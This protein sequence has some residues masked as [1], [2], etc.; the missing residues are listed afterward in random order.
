MYLF[1]GH[2]RWRSDDDL[3]S[4]IDDGDAKQ[5]ISRST[6]MAAMGLSALDRDGGGSQVARGVADDRRSSEVAV[7][8]EAVTTTMRSLVLSQSS[9]GED[10]SE[11]DD[12]FL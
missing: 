7:D 8:V 5:K 9:H 10:E 11:D 6:S 4:T 2:R 3:R 1:G 12:K